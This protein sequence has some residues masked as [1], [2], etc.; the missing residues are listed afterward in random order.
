MYARLLAACLTLC[1]NPA[2]AGQSASPGD[3]LSEELYFDDIPRVLTVS[4]LSQPLSDSP[5]AVTVIDRE[6]IRASGVI[7]LPDIFRLVP[8]FYV[9]VNAGYVHNTNHVVSYHGMTSSYAG[10]MQVLIDGRT[11]YEPLYGGVQWSELPVSIADIERIEVTRGPN[12]ASYGANSFFGVINIITQHPS[13]AQGAMVSMSHGNGRNEAF[14]RYG[15]KRN[16]TSYRVTLGYRQDDGLQD[17][18]DFKRTRMLSARAD[19]RLGDHDELELHFGLTDGDRGEGDPLVDPLIFLPRTKQVATNFQLAKW[20]HSLSQ[21]SDFSLQAY[22]AYSRSDDFFITSDLSRLVPIIFPTRLQYDLEVENERYELEAQHTFSPTD[23]VRMV[24]GGSV[25]QDRTKAPFYLGT[26]KTQ[27]FNLRQLFGHVEWQP[28]NRLV[29]NA[30]AMVEHNDFTGTDTSPRVSAN[31]RLAP[32]HTLRLGVSTATRTPAYL[33][34]KFQSHLIAT[35]TIPGVTLIRPYFADSGGLSPERI[36]SREIGYLGTY[37]SITL[38]ARVF[39]DDIRD[40][41]KEF[42]NR[43]YVPPAGFTRISNPFDF[44]NGG[45]V[46]IRGYEARLQWRMKP[47]TRLIANYARTRLSGNEDELERYFLDSVPAEI[48]SA[49]LSHRFNQAWDASLAYYHTSRVT[50]LGD[51]NR[52]DAARYWDAR[53]ARSF[54]SGSWKGEVSAVV[55]NLFD[56]E[57]QEFAD[58]NTVRRRAFVTLKLDF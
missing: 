44:T 19:H 15:G 7:D 32:G 11:V 16:D 26:D 56:D 3:L 28:F 17:R 30:G 29:L 35:T 48:I 21:R 27:T 49:L 34:E 39:D 58:Y 43:T 38:D 54:A 45:D 20:R 13:E 40:I 12:A 22:R 36:V 6:T 41:V 33:E 24:W 8:G 47:S 46:A 51:G 52:V 31:F 14:Y 2:Q 57:F 9:G 50:M 42:T 25:R 23:S 55:H 4:R 37:G 53:L 5:S 10:R 18:V 1:V